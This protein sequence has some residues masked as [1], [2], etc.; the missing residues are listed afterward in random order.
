MGFGKFFSGR[1][2][3][4]KGD[5]KPEKPK[6]LLAVPPIYLFAQTALARLPEYLAGGGSADAPGHFLEWLCGQEAVYAH[7]IQGNILDIGTPQSLEA[8]RR[9]FGSEGDVNRE[10]G[11]GSRNG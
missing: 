3:A 9:R 4:G 1:S 8:A 6:S 5:E 10:V 11:G 2:N 7:R